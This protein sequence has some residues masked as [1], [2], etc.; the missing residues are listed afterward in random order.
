M[1]VMCVETYTFREKWAFWQIAQPLLGMMAMGIFHEVQTNNHVHSY[2]IYHPYIWA[3]YI[4][5]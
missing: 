5:A 4:W 3:S 1:G 2:I